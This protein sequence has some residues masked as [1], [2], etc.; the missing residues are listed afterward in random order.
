[1][2]YMGRRHPRAEEHPNQPDLDFRDATHEYIIEVEVPGIKKPEEVTVTWT[3]HST[4]LLTGKIER[5]EYDT[6]G[7]GEQPEQH[8]GGIHVML[9]ER[10]VGPFRRY[11]SFPSEVENLKVTLEAGLLYVPLIAGRS[12]SS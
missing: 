10:R 2:Q 12:C 4:L 3:G 1:M 8:H 5:P 11:I 7:K 6:P 9:G